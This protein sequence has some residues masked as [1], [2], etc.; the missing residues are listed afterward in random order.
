[1]IKPV[2][3]R[4]DLQINEEL[5]TYSQIF[6]LDKNIVSVRGILVTADLDDLLYFRGSQRIEINKDEI[7]PEKY[8]SKLLMSGINVPPKM[9]YYDLGGVNPGNGQVKLEYTDNDSNRIAFRTY[10]VSLYLDCDMDDEK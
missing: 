2:K 7:F 1:M 8:E 4:F 10:R 9:R 3:K 5:K 6:E